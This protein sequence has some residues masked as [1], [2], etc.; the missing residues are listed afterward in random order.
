MRIDTLTVGEF[1]VNCYIVHGANGQALVIDPGADAQHIL[2][3]LARKEI[4]VA[5]YVLTHGHT[6]H[7]CALAD[8]HAARPAP[9]AIHA[10]DLE[11]AFGDLNQLPPFYPVPRRPAAV[12]RRLEHGQV[13]T[14]A[15]LTY[16]IVGTPGHTPGSVCLYFPTENAL[17]SG[18]TLFAGS[19]GRTDQPGGNARALAASLGQLARLPDTTVVYPGHGPDTDIGQEKQANF[20][21]QGLNRRSPQ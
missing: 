9:V 3:F 6:D 1:Q 16:T 20:F 14:D 15:G 21:M 12:E 11:W 17:F 10:A 4:T 18:D 19:V 2:G 7:L 13:W 8:L 5:A